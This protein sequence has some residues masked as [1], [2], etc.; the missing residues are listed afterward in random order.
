MNLRTKKALAI[1]TLGVGKERIVFI[2]SRKEE[3]K[4]AITKQDIRD[5]VAEGAII[6]KEVKGRKK[7]KKRKNKRGT[8]KIKKTVNTRKRDYVIMTRKLRKYLKAVKE[9]LGLSREEI[10]DTRNRI[11]N[12]TF[13]SKAVLKEYLEGKKQ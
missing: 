8:G 6:I 1:K 5:L 13:R 7:V 2:E 3:I 11:R 4:E 10:K 9:S 12:K